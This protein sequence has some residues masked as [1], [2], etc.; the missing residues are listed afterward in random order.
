MINYTLIY[1]VSF[2]IV[3]SVVGIK[4]VGIKQFLKNI[5]VG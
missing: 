3:L 2:L 5:K 4:K 1:I